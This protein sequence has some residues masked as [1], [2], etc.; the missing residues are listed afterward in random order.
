MQGENPMDTA[1]RLLDEDGKM[2]HVQQSDV[3]EEGKGYS[4]EK[5][6]EF[7]NTWTTKS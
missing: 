4:F 3:L 6:K 5:V 7:F 1:Q 2:I